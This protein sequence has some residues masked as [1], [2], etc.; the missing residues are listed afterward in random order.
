MSRR[1]NAIEKKQKERSSKFYKYMEKFRTAKGSATQYMDFDAME[2]YMP[3]RK[4]KQTRSM[5]AGFLDDIAA[6]KMADAA[7]KLGPATG[8]KKDEL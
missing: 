1:I 4:Q 7:K 2:Y 5:V 8:K 6:G 3:P